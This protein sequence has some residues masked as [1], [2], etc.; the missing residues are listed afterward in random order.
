LKNIAEW[1][2]DGM[3]SV[4]NFGFVI[5]GSSVNYRFY[6]LSIWIFGNNYLYFWLGFLLGRTISPLIKKS[7]Y[8]LPK[9]KE[10]VKEN[11]KNIAECVGQSHRPSSRAGVLK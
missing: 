8:F 4:Y 3:V 6:K 2:E 7:N 11:L 9:T 10:K 5:T 1:Q